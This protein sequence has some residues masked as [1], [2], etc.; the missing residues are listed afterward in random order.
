MTKA[1]DQTNF[2]PQRKVLL[3][4]VLFFCVILIGGSAAFFFAMQQM[5]RNETLGQLSRI[6][7]TRNL[8]FTT[9]FDSQISLALNM[10]ESPLISAHLKDPDDAELARLAHSEFSANRKSFSG[11]NIFWISNADKRYY[12]NDEYSYTLD[13]ADPANDWYAPT[14]NQR[15]RFSFNVNF[16]IGIK[17]TL[18]WINVPVYDD[19]KTPVGIVG[20]G[21]D[22]T[23][24]INI[25]FTGL[26]E[27]ATLLLFNKSGEITG[28]KDI[29]LMERKVHISEV[30]ESGQQ[31]FF[32]ALS[33]KGGELKTFVL[34]NSAFAVNSIPQLNWYIAVSRPMT[35]VMFLNN[36]MYVFITLIAAI[37]LIFL[38]FN[39][40]IS[41]VLI[42]IDLMLERMRGLS[43]DW[44]RSSQS[45]RIRQ[46]VFVCFAFILM[47][48]IS[49]SATNI[50][51][52]RHLVRHA[53]E[54]LG[55]AEI[56]IKSNLREAASA[57]TATSFIIVDLINRG[58]TQESIL[59]YLINVTNWLIENDEMLYGFNGL[60]G[61]I[62]GDFLDGAQWEPPADYVP[63]E[64]PWFI[65]AKEK[66][67]ELAE[68]L[69]YA[70][71][72]TGEMVI[73][74]TKELFDISGE[75]IGVLGIDV[76]LNQMGEY[77]EG[78]RKSESGYGIMANQNFNIMAHPNDALRG[79]QL[80]SI[81]GYFAEIQEMLTN[82][83]S[84][85]ALSV[86]DSRNIRQIA[87]FK[88][89]YNG[90][91]IGSI[92][93]FHD[94]YRD[95]YIMA[96]IL[97]VVGSVLMSIL[98]LLISRQHRR[99][100]EK[101]KNIL[102]LQDVLLKTMVEMVD[103]RDKIT[104]SHIE[105]TKMG[106]DI[107]LGEIE[108]SGHFREETEGWDRNLLLQSCQLHDVG[109][110]SISDNILNKPGK[111]DNDE[112]EEMRKHAAFG[113]QI[114]EKIE[115]LTKESDFL[116]YT[117]I[118]AASHHEKWDGTGYPLGLK[119]N[120]IPLLGRIMAIADVYDALI[121]NRPY[122][123]A[124]THDEAVLI[125]SDGRDKHFDPVLVDLFLGA[126]EEFRKLDRAKVI[127][128]SSSVA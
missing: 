53:E 1:A 44:K 95:V 59:N 127:P 123:K 88:Q 74:Y 42:P 19:N 128:K 20:T 38:I 22:L 90:W 25:L 39:I 65:V 27:D 30:W 55:N 116:K 106:V 91:Y 64:R 58:E 17:R 33:S 54:L 31:V 2:S 6:I 87:F 83:K 81:N 112:I 34:N 102:E 71:E 67:G 41:N 66:A 61:Y 72:D 104:G 7:E 29:S 15:E 125:I 122:K 119:K 43:T 70:D 13:T 10:A 4:S 94:F 48:A 118:F 93:P 80:N 115:S 111:F 47:I 5:V 120:E 89:L 92:T 52:R 97:T 36:A 108:K 100:E 46:I 73:S 124:Y 45:S 101:T 37:F 49:F 28:A 9:A 16:D 60:Y 121:S 114:I 105:R 117:R 68:T 99:I 77:V 96:I 56:T 75:S 113:E 69:P 8:Q 63:Q 82:G 86:K 3:F 85:A 98:S 11:N 24:Y 35:I 62:R 84:V 23:D 126:S 107:L 32:E 12:F 18:C 79:K 26:G 51:L 57:L 50:I 76:L 110:I 14:L 21:I 78:L 40:Y 103:Y 109:K